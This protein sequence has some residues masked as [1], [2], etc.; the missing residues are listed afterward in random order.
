MLR[1]EL[2]RHSITNE[3]GNADSIVYSS[4]EGWRMV[5]L[6]MGQGMAMISQSVE[7]VLLLYSNKNA[8][9]QVLLIIIQYKES[10]FAY[11]TQFSP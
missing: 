7:M 11:T 10:S 4:G 9:F 1:R 2:A 5:G 8:Y 6:A 3:K